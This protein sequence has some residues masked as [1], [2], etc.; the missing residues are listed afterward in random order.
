MKI[1]VLGGGSWGTAL[2]AHA[3]RAGHPTTLWLREPEIAA[4]IAEH[5]TNAL[6]LPGAELPAELRAELD[7]EV[8]VRDA[9]MVVVAIPSEYCRGIYRRLQGAL[10]SA[11]PVVVSATKGLE[12]ESLLRM[13]EV[14]RSE[15]P[16][17]P[18]AVLSGPS[19][20]L[21]V[22]VG[23][24]T[25]VVA[26][27][28]DLAVAESV[29]RGLS[30]RTFRVYSSPDVVGAE[31]GGA[32]KNVIAI[33][34]GIVDGLGY[35]HNTVAALITRGLAEVTRLAVASGGRADTL[36][37]LA[38]LG[39]LV[40]TCTGRLSRNR[41][42]GQALGRGKGLEQALAESP[43]VAE[44]VRTARAACDLAERRAIEMPIARRM[45]AVLYEGQEPRAAV[46]ELM[47]RSLKR[48]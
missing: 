6:F 41:S 37:G 26:A 12:L 9:A 20:A 24:P 5:H 13:T 11:R 27:S 46:D 40:L 32:L 23:Q 47:L 43:Q 35:G 15:L 14:A 39:D 17:M 7:L 2:A 8:A 18:L 45:R 21:E 33:A 29:Q 28:S 36:A 3:A 25:A 22:A 30:T 4:E 10:G 34:A 31:L 16:E 19:F 38:G 1:A 44:G 42:L 48:E